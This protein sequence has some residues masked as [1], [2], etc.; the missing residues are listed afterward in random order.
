MSDKDR[1][2]PLLEQIITDT[3]KVRFNNCEEQEEAKE[4][5]LETLKTA[6]RSEI[7][8]DKTKTKLTNCGFPLSQATEEVE[9]VYKNGDQLVFQNVVEVEGAEKGHT[10]ILSFM[11]SIHYADHEV[12]KNVN[13]FR[14]DRRS[15]VYSADKDRILEKIRAEVPDLVRPEIDRIVAGLESEDEDVQERSRESMMGI[16]H[17]LQTD[18]RLNPRLTAYDV[19]FNVDLHM[20]VEVERSSY[21][22]PGFITVQELADI[23]YAEEAR[24]QKL[25]DNPKLDLSEKECETIARDEVNEMIK[26]KYLLDD[27]GKLEYRIAEFKG[28][29]GMALVFRADQIDRIDMRGTPANQA[30]PRTIP[31]SVYAKKNPTK[32][33]ICDFKSL[34]DNDVERIRKEAARADDHETLELQNPVALKIMRPE[35]RSADSNKFSKLQIDEANILTTKGSMYGN[36]VSIKSAGM[37]EGTPAIAMEYI[38]GPDLDELVEKC[39]PSNGK[40]SL[41]KYGLWPAAT[42]FLVWQSALALENAHT[43]KPDID[44]DEKTVHRD[45]KESNV[46]ISKIDGEVKLSDFGAATGNLV[47]TGTILGSP[48]YMPQSALRGTISAKNDLASLGV[49]LYSLLTGDSPYNIYENN[50]SVFENNKQYVFLIENFYNRDEHPI[51]NPCELVEG[52]DPEYGEIFFRLMDIKSPEGKNEFYSLREKRWIG[53]GESYYDK[54]WNAEV[55]KHGEAANPEEAAFKAA[56]Y[57]AEELF[58]LTYPQ[59]GPRAGPGL[60]K[61]DLA[62]IITHLI[63]QSGGNKVPEEHKEHIRKRLNYLNTQLECSTDEHGN[64]IEAVKKTDDGGWTINTR[65][66]K[67]TPEADM[68]AR[69]G[70]NPMR[71]FDPFCSYIAKKGEVLKQVGIDIKT[72]PWYN[73]ETVDLL[74]QYIGHL[75]VD[76][77][78]VP[79]DPAN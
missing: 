36:I 65:E 62:A 46:L 31:S 22:N 48:N 58:K 49:M 1:N 79:Q 70:V 3:N 60:I 41:N 37:I 12:E 40:A 6:I 67:Y 57:A 76:S 10:D 15:V 71:P 14:V 5:V 55:E 20:T 56:S 42:A 19:D 73:K 63:E 11:F 64:K 26:G 34:D 27:E 61:P 52:L 66:I 25:I 13:R 23:V 50:R 21:Q 72:L 7:Q 9:L 69:A 78:R 43:R 47:P 45:V 54:A 44:R 35:L 4:H 68:L 75:V 59:S 39:A 17:G 2:L 33:T 16:Y 77:P 53:Y 32:A 28:M 24:I 51:T 29:G 38:N 74:A 30:E 8:R 18:G